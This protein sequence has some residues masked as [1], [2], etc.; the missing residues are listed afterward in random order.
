MTAILFCFVSM[1]CAGIG[2]TQVAWRAYMFNDRV[3]Q[4]AR[5]LCVPANVSTAPKVQL[6]T[7]KKEKKGEKRAHKT[8]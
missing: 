7:P 5:A 6:C 3:C 2:L 1:H 4:R 8:S